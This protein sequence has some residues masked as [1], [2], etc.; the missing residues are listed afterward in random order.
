MNI[1]NLT[2][3]VKDLLDIETDAYD[4]KVDILVLSS[5]SKLKNEGVDIDLLPP[6]AATQADFAVCVAHQVAQDIDL[7]VNADRLA[8]LYHARVQT[9][10]LSGRKNAL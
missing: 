10:K 3:Q 8:G 1:E 9:L 4:S 2:S 6:D 5:I 7:D